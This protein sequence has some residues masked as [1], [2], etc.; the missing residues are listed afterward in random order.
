MK[1]RSRNPALS[2]VG[3][4]PKAILRSVCFSA[5]CNAQLADAEMAAQI[6]NIRITDV[7]NNELAVKV[8]ETTHLPMDDRH[9]DDLPE[10]GE[11][12]EFLHENYRLHITHSEVQKM[13]DSAMY[14]YEESTMRRLSEGMTRHTMDNF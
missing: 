2:S 13:I 4:S 9:S 8:P 14:R 3:S 1:T 5:A 10:S 6:T 7:W 12:E 11:D